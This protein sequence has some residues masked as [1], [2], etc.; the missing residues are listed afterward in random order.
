MAAN[1]IFPIKAVTWGILTDT[2]IRKLSVCEVTTPS[3]RNSHGGD[4]TGT[5]YDARMGVLGSGFLCET[6][7]LD[8]RGC[9]GHFGHIALP[10]QVY[11]IM[12]MDHILKLLQS[13]CSICARPRILKEHLLLMGI[14][15]SGNSR[16]RSIAL[17]SDKILVCPWEDCKQPLSTFSIVDGER[18]FRSPPN[19]DVQIEFG[20][21]EALNIF[22][23]I[24]NA[25]LHILGFNNN[26]PSN[27]MFVRDDILTFGKEHTLQ[28]RPESLIFSSFPVIP[29][30]ARPYIIQDGKPCDDD[31][32]EK[33]NS[34]I[35]SCRKLQPERRPSNSKKKMIVLTETERRKIEYEISQHIWTLMHNKKE[36]SKV[37]VGGRPHKGLYERIT[38][39]EGRI[40][41]NIRGKRAD[42]SART[43][44]VGGGTKI[45]ADEVGVPRH[46]AEIIT[47]PFPVTDQNIHIF[48]D[49]LS[50]KKINRITRGTT[51]K[52]LT[53]MPDRG[54]KMKLCVG[55]IVD[56]QLQD[57]EYPIVNRQPTLRTESMMSMKVK[58]IEGD[59]MRIPACMT[60]SYNADFDKPYNLAFLFW[61]Y[62][63]LSST[64]RKRE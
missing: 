29:P 33:Y 7:H 62:N 5:P 56:L 57:G 11:N 60:R 20:A 37:S 28:F 14:R 30:I 22:K 46:I 2:E 55:D 53:V 27:A 21:G 3:Q 39:K 19:S 44:I 63:I 41:N 18:I 52:N 17:K 31:L 59:A 43:V 42:F 23:R 51:T 6:C 54:C 9:P 50:E 15:G 1:R 4:S 8:N 36:K 13:V 64:K 40:Q 45:R 32:T 49:F 24:T 58:I 26:L 10:I 48:Q 34:I 38:S 25:T 47:I 12:Y 61:E 16:L 35:K